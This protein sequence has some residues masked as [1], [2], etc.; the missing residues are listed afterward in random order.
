MRAVFAVPSWLNWE[1]VLMFCV[2]WAMLFLVLDAIRKCVFSILTW[3]YPDIWSHKA[4]EAHELSPMQAL[5]QAEEGTMPV[6]EK[7]GEA[8]K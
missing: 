8:T 1:S 5:T 7:T 2:V 3:F 4:L 6:N